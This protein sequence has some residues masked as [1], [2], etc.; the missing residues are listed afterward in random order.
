M[1]VVIFR[2]FFMSPVIALISSSS[3][4]AFPALSPGFTVFGEIF[5][6]VTFL[7]QL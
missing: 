7:I 4:S 5:G 3:S 2:F 1:I 6:N